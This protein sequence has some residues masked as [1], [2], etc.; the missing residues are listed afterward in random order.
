MGILDKIFKD[1][2]VNI[3]VYNFVC[4]DITEMFIIQGLR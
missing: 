3:E 1:N 4:E 2:K